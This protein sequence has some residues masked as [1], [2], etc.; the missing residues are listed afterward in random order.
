VRPL[1]LLGFIAAI[2]S[3]PVA[4][5]QSKAC[6][7]YKVEVEKSL[8]EAA[9]Y[10]NPEQ[11]SIEWS[12]Q[13]M[14]MRQAKASNYYAI[15]ALNLQLAMASKCDVKSWP[16]I[17]VKTYAESARLCLKSEVSRIVRRE[18]DKSAFDHPECD[19]DSWKP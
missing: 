12:H 5:A 15:I 19:R 11:D 6:D 13:G 1:W 9:F 14:A 7:G 4:V 3:S 18:K 10:I 8:K 16:V 2:L 17:G